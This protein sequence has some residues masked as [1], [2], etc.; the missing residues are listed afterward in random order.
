MKTRV[1]IDALG[2]LKSHSHIGKEERHY[3]IYILNFQIWGNDS[4][5]LSLS[6]AYEQTS[7]SNHTR[8]NV[9]VIIAS[10]LD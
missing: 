2:D 9:S 4:N 7:N 3:H 1:N 8:T 10:S 5:H 6:C